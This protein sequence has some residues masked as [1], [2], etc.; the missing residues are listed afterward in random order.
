VLII[1]IVTN[2]PDM[3]QAVRDILLPDWDPLGIGANVSLADEYDAYLPTLLNLLAHG[4]S[5]QQVMQYL[6]SIETA[7]GGVS[8]SERRL[9]TAWRLI[10]TCRQRKPRPYSGA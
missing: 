1:V 8:A 10:E 7:L 2:I 5:V 9:R 3:T 6:E 4:P